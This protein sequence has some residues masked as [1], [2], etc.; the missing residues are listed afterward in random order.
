MWPGFR[1]LVNVV[2]AMSSFMVATSASAW[3]DTPLR[4]TPDGAITD[5]PGRFD[6]ASMIV[7]F[8][9]AGRGIDGVELSIAR[10]RIVFPKCLLKRLPA[11]SRR[12]VQIKGAWHDTAGLEPSLTVEFR[13]PTDRAGAGSTSA[14]FLY[15]GLETGTL[16][17]GTEFHRRGA[18]KLGISAACFRDVSESTTPID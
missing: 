7:R 11:E 9:D 16:W 1:M 14:T 8:A 18:R 12:D 3:E 17:H 2:A 4:W 15:F 6:P 13:S 5:F 10:K